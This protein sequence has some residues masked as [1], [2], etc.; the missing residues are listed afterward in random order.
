MFKS[1]NMLNEISIKFNS[2]KTIL[3]RIHFLQISNEYLCKYIKFTA[4]QL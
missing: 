1:Q 3:R 4:L 2:S